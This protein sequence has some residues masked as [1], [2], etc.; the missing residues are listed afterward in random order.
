MMAVIRPSSK[1][2]A[3]LLPNPNLCSMPKIADFKIFIPLLLC[4]SA[5]KWGK[6]TFYAKIYVDLSSRNRIEDKNCVR[7]TATSFNC[8]FFLYF[9]A[10][11]FFPRCLGYPL[12]HSLCTRSGYKQTKH[13]LVLLLE[14]Y[15]KKSIHFWD[16]F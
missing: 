15:Q 7:Y 8:S 13:C 16:M 4:H 14:K 1:H 11:A 9:I 2:I 6:N 5:L 12:Y 3:G 10:R